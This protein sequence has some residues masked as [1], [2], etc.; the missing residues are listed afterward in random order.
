MKS[1][2]VSKKRK[3]AF[4]FRKPMLSLESVDNIL[5]REVVFYELLNHLRLSSLETFTETRKRRS[6]YPNTNDGKKC[7]QSSDD[8]FLFLKESLV[9]ESELRQGKSEER[10][11][12]NEQFYNTITQQQKQLQIAWRLFICCAY[13]FFVVYLLRRT[14][15]SERFRN[16]PVKLKLEEMLFIDICKKLLLNSF[17]ATDFLNLWLS[18]VFM[19][20]RKRSVGLNRLSNSSIEFFNKD[21]FRTI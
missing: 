5:I 7:R 18:V 1:Y 12:S 21:I 6:E 4:W 14:F 9:K 19:K 10:K 11:Q 16:I 17:H 20:Y 15:G 2:Q 8:F 3:I 13:C